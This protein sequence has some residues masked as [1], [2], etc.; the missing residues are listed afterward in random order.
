MNNGE[1]VRNLREIHKLTQRQ[2]GAKSG[3]SHCA[4]WRIENNKAVRTDT[5]ELV[6]AALGCHWTIA[7]N[8]PWPANIPP[9]MIAAAMQ[10]EVSE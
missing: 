5:L 6:L 3:T 4:V 7:A 10:E 8:A 1:T 9:A 2:L